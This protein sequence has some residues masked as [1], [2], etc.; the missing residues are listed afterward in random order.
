MSRR[1]PAHWIHISSRHCEISYDEAQARGRGCCAAL[2]SR[3]CIPCRRACRHLGLPPA[4]CHCLMVILNWPHSLS[5]V[6]GSWLVKDL[7]TNGT[8]VNGH[9]VG[10]GKTGPVKPGDRVRLPSWLAGSACMCTLGGGAGV[11]TTHCQNQRIDAA[12][13]LSCL[14]RWLWRCSPAGLLPAVAPPGTGA[15]HRAACPWPRPSCCVS[16]RCS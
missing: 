11:C 3:R 2:A 7:S 4:S 6:Q 14:P 16:C 5:A 12:G 1:L 10:K 9:K 13:P 8:F 15:W